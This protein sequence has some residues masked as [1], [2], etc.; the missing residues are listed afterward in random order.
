LHFPIGHS[1]SANAPAA[2]PFAKKLCNQFQPPCPP[3]AHQHSLATPEGCPCNISSWLGPAMDSGSR[4]GRCAAHVTF[5][6]TRT[7]T[8]GD[9]AQLSALSG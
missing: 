8:A 7:Q 4:L 1:N 9:V 2:H 3:C 6:C 5:F